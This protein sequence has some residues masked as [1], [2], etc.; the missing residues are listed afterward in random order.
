M[1]DALLKLTAQK[2]R[3]AAALKERIEKL[4]AKL[5]NIL[6]GPANAIN[7]KLGKRRRRLSASARKRISAAQKA[8]WAKQK[9]RSPK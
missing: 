6:A 2:L 9:A 1:N 8:R 3:H 4:Q 5:V 7:N